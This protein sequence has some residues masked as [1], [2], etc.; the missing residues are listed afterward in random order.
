[1]TGEGLTRAMDDPSRPQAADSLV[2]ER[3]SNHPQLV[4][5]LDE[6]ILAPD[7]AMAVVHV[8]DNALG[9]YLTGTRY[10]AP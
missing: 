4:R 6:E 1:M 2:R 10:A 7:E 8:I 3:L 5:M 9:R